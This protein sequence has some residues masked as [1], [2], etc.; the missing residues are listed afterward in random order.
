MG[1]VHGIGPCPCDLM[2]VGEGPGF[3]EDRSGRPFVG[4]PGAEI[5][6]YLDGVEL[7]TRREW[8]LSNVYRQFGGKDYVWTS[9]DLERDE[10]RLL[11][12]LARVQPR[13]I[14]TL[15]RY[16]ARWF[17]GDIDL[18]AVQGIPFYLSS[19][20]KLSFLN[21]ET[22]VLAI[23][24]PAAGL[25]NPEMSPHVV[26]G[27]NQLAMYLRGE[28]EPRKLFDDP[29]ARKEQYV[30]I[31]T[32]DALIQSLAACER[33]GRI[34]LDTEGYTHNPWSLQ[35][36]YRPG[37]AYL[38]RASRPDL[39]AAFYRSACE[40]DA[41]L[42]FHSAL[43]DLGMMRAM[44]I[45]WHGEFED[46]MVASYLLQLTPQGLKQSCLRYCG[47]QMDSFDDVMG[48]TSDALVRDY[49]TWL[50]DVENTDYEE[51]CNDELIRLQTTPYVDTRGKE[52]PGRRLTKAPALPKSPLH[53][54]VTRVIQSKH[55]RKLWL[56]QVEDIQVEGYRR[57]GPLPEATL[58]YVSPERAISYGCR[59]ADGTTRLLPEYAKRIDSLG[60]RSVYNLELSTYPLID[61][62]Q[63]IGFKP[64]LEHFAALSQRLG[65]E[66]DR[67]R[68]ELGAA[69]GRDSFN[70]NSGD[71][72]ADYLFGALNLQEMKLTR[73]G[74]GSTNDKILEALEHEHPEWPVIATIREYRETY[75]LKFTFCDRLKDY[76]NRWPHD[77]RIHAT[78]RTTR[79]VTGRLATSSPN[80]LAMPKHGK[81]A[82]EF[83]RGW[84]CDDG[85]LMGSWDLS[86]IEL[87]VAAHLSQDPV[88]L[89][90]YRGERRNP[91]GS[92]ID[93]HASLAE[94]I[95]GVK[96]SQQDDSKHRLPAKAINFG[97]WMG[98][99]NKG[100]LVELRKNGIQV[101]EDDAQ[102]W[103]DEA[104][105]L[106]TGAQPY[107]DRQAAEAEKNGYIRC[108]DGRIRYIGGIRSTD[109]RTREEAKRFAFSTPVQSGAQTVMKHNEAVLWRDI[110]CP[111]QRQG[112]WIEPLVQIHDDLVL[113]M[114]EDLI[115]E[116]APRMVRCMTES[117]KGLSVPIKTSSSAGRNWADLKEIK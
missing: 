15:G 11:A 26:D 69:T 74:R 109:G 115:H 36:A 58:D 60:L 87:R 51:A 13:T 111:L 12:E 116:V 70:A 86:Q 108:M 89:A 37:I 40:I 32:E 18:D 41:R 54:A 117:Y 84:V 80:I 16:A 67:L 83:R 100:L 68:G 92:M 79:V 96:P 107:M 61:R 1:M 65:G 42:V 106:Y 49:L 104:H 75:K 78:F 4:K 6:R 91:D 28:I 20:E 88:M 23:T 33:G 77:G 93:L 14:V 63:H 114:Q 55:P 10:P 17:L 97:F 24:H 35:F 21:P 38:I 8:F 71:Q 98:Q 46:T 50:W 44:G 9:A 94:R 81:F 56:D 34:S 30:E 90:V 48:D 5:D 3:A 95:F 73:S 105:T 47:M 57:L 27:F 72:V 102:R 2:M 66:I 19:V 52:R 62:M 29:Y 53:K 113:E 31:L 101:D 99:T 112:K 7:P 43:H 22:V 85:H 39:L 45:P 110:I 103:L 25:R 64:D 59:D 82:K 76:V